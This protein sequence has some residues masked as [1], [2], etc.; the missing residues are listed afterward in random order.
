MRWCGVSELMDSSSLGPGWVASEGGGF[1]GRGLGAGTRNDK[2]RWWGGDVAVGRG[3]A[4]RWDTGCNGE[5]GGFV[6][7]GLGAGTR[8]D[9]TR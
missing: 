3:P 1:V 9:K 7:R 5:G 4:A 6:V 2:T 8:N